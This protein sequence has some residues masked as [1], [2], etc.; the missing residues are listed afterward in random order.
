M[1]SDL[2][3]LDK[4]KHKREALAGG[5][6]ILMGQ[7]KADDDKYAM[8]LGEDGEAMVDELLRHVR[9]FMVQTVA[10]MRIV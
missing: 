9:E 6:P 1:R 8:M 3:K 4:I 10:T 2:K 5:K 7:E